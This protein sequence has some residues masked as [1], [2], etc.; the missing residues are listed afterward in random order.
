MFSE[1]LRRDRERCG[2]SVGRAAYQLRL[3]P[4]RYRELELGEAWPDWETVLEDLR[5][6]L[7]AAELRR[8]TIQAGIDIVPR[9]GD[10]P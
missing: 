4:A 9:L 2:L 10:S 7:L 5:A 6:V 8:V 3:T 1:L